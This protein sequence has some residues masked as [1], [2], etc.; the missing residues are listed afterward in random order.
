M[1]GMMTAPMIII[2]LLLMRSMYPEKRMNT[3]II[4]VSLLMLLLFII[5][6][7]NQSAIH[8]K[9]F[10]KSMIPHHASALLM[11]KNASFNDPEIKILCR[12][13]IASQQSEIDW[14]KKKL[15]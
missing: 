5:L 12:T 4:S 8:D 10:L 13:I 2:E 6:I 15:K 11:C 14:M 7:R 9:E 3:V 1:A